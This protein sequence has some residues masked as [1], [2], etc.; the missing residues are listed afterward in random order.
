MT[1]WVF[2][3]EEVD[4]MFAFVDNFI[5]LHPPGADAAG[6]REHADALFRKMGIKL[7]EEEHGVAFPFLGWE[8]DLAWKG[9][10]PWVMVLICPLEKYDAFVRMFRETAA[11]ATVSAKTLL[12]LA[13]VLGWVHTAFPLAGAY[14]P[15]VASQRDRAKVYASRSGQSLATAQ[16]EVSA[17]MR[18]AMTWCADVFVG[19]DRVCPVRAPFGPWHGAQR[20]GWV[21]ASTGFGIGGVF[22]DPG[23]SPPVLLGFSRPWTEREKRLA[24][25]T[26]RE[27]S[28]VME[29]MGLYV[30]AMW[31]ADSCKGCRLN[32]RTDSDAV[33]KACAKAFSERPNMLSYLH[34]FRVLLAR[35]FVDCRVS[36][37]TGVLFNKIADDLSRNDIEAAQ[38]Q[39]VEVFGCRIVMRE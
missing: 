25:V 29:M 32:L 33:K 17:R 14:V 15:M 5:Q 2:E 26:E 37:V 28:G 10:H 21:D 19:W 9:D 30:W 34:D 13:G 7:H 38:C 18:E 8:W 22:F 11:A 23:A 1:L 36:A 16:W 31:F 6:E 27:S 35:A 3:K 39:A 4:L 24:F 12:G 20:H